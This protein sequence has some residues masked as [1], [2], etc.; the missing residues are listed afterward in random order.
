MEKSKNRFPSIA[1]VGGAAMTMLVLFGAVENA[2]SQVVVNKRQYKEILLQGIRSQESIGENVAEFLYGGGIQK[3]IQAEVKKYKVTGLPQDTLDKPEYAL[4]KR[5]A[6]KDGEERK[7]V[8]DIQEIENKLA[9]TL[10]SLVDIDGETFLLAYMQYE[11]NNVVGHKKGK[12]EMGEGYHLPAFPV[13]TNIDYLNKNRA[14]PYS[15]K[16]LQV[17]KAKIER[18][19]NTHFSEMKDQAKTLRVSL[20][21]E[22]YQYRL[23]MSIV[24]AT[25]NIKNDLKKDVLKQIVKQTI[26]EFFSRKND[27]VNGTSKKVPTKTGNIQNKPQG[28]NKQRKRR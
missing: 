27:A 22:E 2:D 18:I 3:L 26:D 23:A 15:H 1:Q 11:E 14:I 21:P 17:L 20:K 13:V 6:I 5:P 8:L 28:N 25:T 19:Y 10:D 4:V 24:K 9:H 16:Q 12:G 7:N